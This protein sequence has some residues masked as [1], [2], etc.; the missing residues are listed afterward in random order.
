M[1]YISHE[2]LDAQQGL[3]EARKH[4]A[5]MS[6]FYCTR[7]HL[8][9]AESRMAAS[10][11]ARRELLSGS[12]IFEREGVH[13]L[14]WAAGQVLGALENVIQETGERHRLMHTRGYDVNHVTK[15]DSKVLSHLREIP[16]S[17]FMEREDQFGDE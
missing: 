17:H 9:R 11:D 5:Q 16:I 13:F 2:L 15:H 4:L 1:D 3:K 10:M 7:K 8:P 12:Y 6:H 14:F